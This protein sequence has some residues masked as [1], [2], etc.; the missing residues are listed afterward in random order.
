MLELSAIVQR[1][2]VDRSFVD[3]TVVQLQRWPA[4][5]NVTARRYHTQTRGLCDC[6]GLQASQL[7]M[8]S[9]GRS[10]TRRQSLRSTYRIYLHI[11]RS[12][13]DHVVCGVTESRSFSSIAKYK[14]VAVPW[15]VHCGRYWCRL[16]YSAVVCLFVRVL[17]RISATSRKP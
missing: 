4:T 6:V 12:T 7:T 10:V 2:A 16:Q 13:F 11:S 15:S 17:S 14:H 3:R 8:G 1:L 5:D 9:V